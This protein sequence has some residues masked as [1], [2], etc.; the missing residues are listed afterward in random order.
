MSRKVASFVL[1]GVAK[2]LLTA[3]VVLFGLS[4]TVVAFVGFVPSGRHGSNATYTSLTGDMTRELVLAYELGVSHLAGRFIFYGIVTCAFALAAIFF[5][6]LYR[7]V[8]SSESGDPFTT[9]NAGRL[10]IMG[11]ILL[12]PV[13][14]VIA[15]RIARLAPPAFSETVN[16]GLL[17][18][19]GLVLLILASVFRRGAAMR[20]ELDGTV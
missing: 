10:A 11:W 20:E 17:V 13:A 5:A 2:M 1:Y 12:A 18:L 8:R 3:L 16:M 7:I 4:A 14:I 6:Q 9:V 19:A 15:V